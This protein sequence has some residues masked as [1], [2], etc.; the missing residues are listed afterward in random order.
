MNQDNSIAEVCCRCDPADTFLPDRS[1]KRLEEENKRLKEELEVLKKFKRKYLPTLGELLDRLTI[2]QIK[3]VKIPEHKDKYAQE[4]REILHDIDAILKGNEIV[5][6]AGMLR[7]LIVLAQYN[8]HIWHNE[9]N[10]RKGI[11]E[12]NDLELTHGLNSIRNS[13]KNRIQDAMGGRKDYKLDNVEAFP[14]WIP[15]WSNE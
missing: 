1:T 6:D 5:F 11:R 10:F 14:D 13:A 15:S 7:A 3:E 12:G 2:T 4:I 8:L 9:S